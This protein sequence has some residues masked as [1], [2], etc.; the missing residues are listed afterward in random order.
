M[1]NFETTIQTYLENR[2]KED[3]LFAETYKK[4]NKSIEECCKYIMQQAQKMYN[5]RVN[6]ERMETVEVSL[7]TFQVIQSRAICNHTSAYHNRIIELVNRN[8][9]LI[10][11][12]R[13]KYR[14]PQYMNVNGLT[15]AEVDEE[16]LSNLRKG[17]PKY[18]IIRKVEK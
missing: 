12:L 7:K 14:L 9:G 2:A 8:M 6:G 1:S 13:E 10:R 4:E 3:S 5:K 11:R 15:E 18:L 17:E 16:T